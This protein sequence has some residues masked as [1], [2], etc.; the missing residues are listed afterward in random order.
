MK[1]SKTRSAA[2]SALKLSLRV[3]L[4]AVLVIPF[5][6]LVNRAFGRAWAVNW[7]ELLLIW[8]ILAAC[9]FLFVFV[10]GLLEFS[11]ALR[12]RRNKD[13]IFPGVM[14]IRGVCLMGIALGLIL[15]VAMYRE[16]DGWWLVALVSGFVFLGVFAWPRAI[17]ITD[18]ALCQRSNLFLMKRIVRGEIEDVVYDPSSQ[19][20][21]V[22]GKDGARIVHTESHSDGARF[23][24]AMKTFSRKETVVLGAK[25]QH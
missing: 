22:N 20:I 10:T 12:H 21:V 3:I 5:V 7:R 2:V 9:I 17:R 18:S 4:T 11:A 24:S 25:M 8:G 6:S 14:W 19:E 1:T 23:M 15:M 16:G 13:L